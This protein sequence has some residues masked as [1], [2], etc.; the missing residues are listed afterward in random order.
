MIKICKKMSKR[1]KMIIKII[2]NK[3]EEIYYEK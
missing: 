3:R 1:I 2:N